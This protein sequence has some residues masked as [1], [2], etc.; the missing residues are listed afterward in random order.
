MKRPLALLALLV[1]A[2]AFAAVFAP[3]FPSLAL[4]YGSDDNSYC[5]LVPVIFAWM[6]FQLRPALS[7]VMGGGY[8][9]SGAFFLLAGVSLVAGLA[10]ALETLVYV[11][12]WATV[13]G[14]TLAW[15][16][17]RAA[18]LLAF[19]LFVLAFAVPPPPFLAHQ[20]TFSLR[21]FSSAAAVELLQ[22]V[23]VAVFRD[24]NIIDLGEVQLHIVDACSG[25]RFFFPSLIVAMVMGWLF[26]KR[27]L[28][29]LAL[30]ALAPA[31]AVGANALRIAFL[32]IMVEY[33]S[34][35]FID[36]FLH[37]FSG[38]VIFVVT[39]GVLWL[40][41]RLMGQDRKDFS[42]HRAPLMA[43]GPNRGWPGLLAGLAILLAAFA[44]GNAVTRAPQELPR[45]DLGAFPMRI[46]DWTGRA[47]AMDPEILSRLWTDDEL[48]AHYTN[49]ET[50]NTLQ[51]LIS[52]YAH[53]STG[54]TAHAPTS[55]LL[56]GG[57]AIESDEILPPSPET[58]RPFPVHRMVLAWRGMRLI[59]VFWF[60][61]RGRHLTGEW[62]NKLH[63]ILDALTT[64][65]SDG[66]LVRVEMGLLP[67]QDVAQGQRLLDPFLAGVKQRLPGFVP[68]AGTTAQRGER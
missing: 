13:C 55:C 22:A 26:H 1:L 21:L 16:G 35:A 15:F 58:G 6:L 63:L 25:L 7:G 68:G 32:G 50:G 33:V 42:A 38:W 62:E 5:Y 29:R 2:G 20:M 19:P 64:G 18:R 56:G 3:H 47:E 67:S 28:K 51:L 43:P 31:M 14:A 60:E 34:A 36:T 66:A 54:H 24:G 44:A 37:E 8:L 9:L 27:A 59:S 23:G 30:I 61:Q 65:R 39:I 12:M 45:T 48:L 10:G 57:F 52:Y 41:S 46:H 53:Q 49:T 4:R 40:V 11:A 17:D